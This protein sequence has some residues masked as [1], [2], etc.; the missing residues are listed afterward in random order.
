MR[1]ICLD[2][3]LFFPL[4]SFSIH[5]SDCIAFCKLFI[6]TPSV[7]FKESYRKSPYETHHS[8]YYKDVADN[9]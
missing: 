1:A 8:V 2:P 5:T 7:Y 3:T 6:V 4:L 9:I